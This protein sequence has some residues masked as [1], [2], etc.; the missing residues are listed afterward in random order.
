M[1]KPIKIKGSGVISSMVQSNCYIVME[2]NLEGIGQG[3]RCNVLLY[4]SLQI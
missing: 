4:R 1:V 3:E 2:E